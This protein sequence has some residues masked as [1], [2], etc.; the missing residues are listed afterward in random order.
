[1]KRPKLQIALDHNTLASALADVKKIGE[2]VDVIEVGTIL[3]LQ[4]GS[5]PIE[6]MR[7]MFPEKTIV[8]DT[9]CADAG[10][11]VAGNVAQAGADF[12]TVICCASL[13]TMQA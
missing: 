11:T 9:K 8:A 4:E 5:K 3:C 1:M 12:M 7:K 2:I 10:E 13:A 6:C